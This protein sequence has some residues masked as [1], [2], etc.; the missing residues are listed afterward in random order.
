MIYKV[1]AIEY[2][3]SGLGSSYNCTITDQKQSNVTTTMANARVYLYD[4]VNANNT[5]VNNNNTVTISVSRNSGNIGIARYTYITN[6]SS[7]SKALSNV[8]S[9]NFT[10][11]NLRDPGAKIVFYGGGTGN[12]TTTGVNKSTTVEGGRT[13]TIKASYRVSVSTFSYPNNNNITVTVTPTYTGNGD[14]LDTPNYWNHYWNVKFNGITQGNYSI[15]G[16][17]NT[18]AGYFTFKCPYDTNWTVSPPKIEVYCS[19]IEAYYSYSASE[20]QVYGGFETNSGIISGFPDDGT[21]KPDTSVPSAQ[22][23]LVPGNTRFPNATKYNGGYGTYYLCTSVSGYPAWVYSGNGHEYTVP[24]PG[25]IYSG[26]VT[27][28]A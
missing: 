1:L 23:Y 10:I 17:D 6:N 21:G 4:I 8:S 11:T 2:H 20:Q 9:T 26:Y 16:N 13:F 19:E 7:T 24:E 5:S 25:S 28:Y 14:G 3:P 12:I 27:Y 22:Q 15:S 18:G